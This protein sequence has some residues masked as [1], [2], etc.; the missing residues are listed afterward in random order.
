MRAYSVGAPRVPQ[1]RHP[2]SLK[3]SNF[4]PRK[5]ISRQ[6]SLL[7]PPSLDQISFWAPSGCVSHYQQSTF[8][9]T[10]SHRDLLCRWTQYARFRLVLAVETVL[11][12]RAD[13]INSL[14]Q[15]RPCPFFA[16]ID[17][18][19]ISTECYASGTASAR[20]D[21]DVEQFLSAKMV[22][23]AFVPWND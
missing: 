11:A 20:V 1:A 5:S 10:L 18:I 6:L 7:T 9:Q 8:L 13:V 14:G 17:L 23:R 4:S 22:A 21:C 2:S 19:C 16:S 12:G 3:L 15:V